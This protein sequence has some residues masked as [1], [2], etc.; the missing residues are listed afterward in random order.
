[1]LQVIRY[2]NLAL[3]ALLGTL[4]CSAAGT[5]GVAPDDVSA[6]GV[7]QGED[8][9]VLLADEGAGTLAAGSCLAGITNYASAGP[10]QYRT[11]TVGARDVDEPTPGR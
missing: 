9:D 3:C 8:E 4:G 5:E 2:P 6:A 7:S 11:R 10:F 1:M